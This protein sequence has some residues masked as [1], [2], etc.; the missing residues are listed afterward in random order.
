VVRI[1]QEGFPISLPFTRAAEIFEALSFDRGWLPFGPDC[2]EE[3]AKGYMQTLLGEFLADC[4]KGYQ[5]GKT[6]GEVYM[7][8]VRKD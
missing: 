4:G 8:G 7:E 1:R 6:K 5:F 2:S 3:V